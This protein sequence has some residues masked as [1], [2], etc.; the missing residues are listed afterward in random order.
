MPRPVTPEARAIEFDRSQAPDIF[1]VNTLD[2]DGALI[3]IIE[4]YAN[5]DE[6][7]SA[8]AALAKATGLPLMICDEIGHSYL[9]S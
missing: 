1:Y 5:A 8:A 3:D 9:D 2:G 6:A 4:E 7:H